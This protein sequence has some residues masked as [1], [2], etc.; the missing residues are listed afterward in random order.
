MFDALVRA[1]LDG[2]FRLDPLAATA[3]TAARV[4]EYGAA[5]PDLSAIDR[6]QARWVTVEAATLTFDQAIDGDRLLAILA[7]QRYRLA[8]PTRCPSR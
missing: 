2:A 5:W 6:W 7:V 1:Y 3:A 8:A 4:H